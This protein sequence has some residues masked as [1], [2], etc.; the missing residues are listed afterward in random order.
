VAPAPD[1]PAATSRAA[2]RRFSAGLLEMGLGLGMAEIPGVMSSGDI[3]QAA[4]QCR[5]W[6]RSALPLVLEPVDAI[7]GVFVGL[8]LFFTGR[9][10]PFAFDVSLVQRVVG[11]D[12]VALGHPVLLARGG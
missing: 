5:T 12:L 8:A 1:G 3:Q 10:A 6:S 7:C 11:L 2:T 9:L 4:C